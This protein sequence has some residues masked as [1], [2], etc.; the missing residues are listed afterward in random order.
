MSESRAARTL[1]G[2]ISAV[3]TRPAPRRRAGRGEPARRSP[4][5]RA[6]AQPRRASR[7]T[8]TGSGARTSST[9]RVSSSRPERRSRG[10]EAE[11]DRLPVRDGVAGGRLER[12]RERVAEVQ[13]RARAVLARVAKADGRLERRAAPHLLGP[14]EL[15]HRLAQRED[16]SSR[17]R[18]GRCGAP[19]P[20]ACRAASCRRPSRAASGTRRRGSS[21]REVDPD[22]AADRGVDLPDERRRDGDP[23]DPAQVAGCDE[24]GEVG[25]R[26]S[27]DRGER[28]RAVERQR[29]PQALGF[30]DRL[31]RLPGGSTCA[32]ADAV[33]LVDARV[34]HDGVGADLAVR[35]EPDP[36]GR[37]HGAVGIADRR[38]GGLVEGAP[39][40]WSDRNASRS[41][42]RGRSLAATRSQPSSAET[43]RW[44]R[45]RVLG[46]RRTGALGAER[47]PPSSTTASGALH[48][49]LE[50]RLLLELAEGRLAARLEDLGDR[51]ACCAPRPRAST[52]TNG[53]PSRSASS[54]P[55][56]DFP[57]PM[58][59]TRARCRPSAFAATRCAR[60]RRAWAP[61]KSTS[62]SPP[63][64][65]RAARAS[66]QRDRGLRDDRERLDRLHV[67][68]L[69]ERLAGL[70]ARRGRRSGAGA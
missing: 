19:P 59:P 25:R 37:E 43:S 56:V 44:T 45:E 30:G 29:T 18:R 54:A 60:G 63:N 35:R 48:Q 23:V 4:S 31:R 5:C 21:L 11:R 61:T 52:S 40:P 2:S 42:A 50:R 62:A 6:G 14:A 34:G 13:L 33:E 1:A 67:A 16:P 26:A 41:R 55:S 46:Q 66:S 68:A 20:G 39:L 8:S 47:P 3:T 28:R 38:V 12:V 51:R 70:A 53:R 69:D 9:V 65:S 10:E 22:L 32:R 57:A 49:R 36:R 24:A 58:K 64:F 7:S 27:A 17:P 15:P